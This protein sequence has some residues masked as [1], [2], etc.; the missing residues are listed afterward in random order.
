MFAYCVT[1]ANRINHFLEIYF[2][3]TCSQIAASIAAFKHCRLKV[4]HDRIFFFPSVCSRHTQYFSDDNDD[5][6]AN[7]ADDDYG[8]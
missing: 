2:H 8:R 6:D 4:C 7:D 1:S 3:E 5:A